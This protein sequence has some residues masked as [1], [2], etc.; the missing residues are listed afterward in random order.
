MAL[1]IIGGVLLSYLL[2]SIPT[3]FWYGKIF[4][5]IDIRKHGSGN[6][7]ATNSLR[8]MGREAGIIVI[9]IDMLKGVVAV[10]IAR[11]LVNYNIIQPSREISYELIF[12]IIAV[13]GHIFPVYAKFKGGKGI[14]T[15]FGMILAIDILTAG[16]CTCVFLLVLL[17]T[18]YVSLGSIMATISFPVM[19]LIFTKFREGG[20]SIMPLGIII[21]FIVL[22]THRKN[23]KRIFKGEERKFNL[24][25]E[26]NNKG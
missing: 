22:L 1:Y 18:R 9:L 11:L 13:I 3:A 7:G 25:K 14:A 5:D 16:I 12:A 20:P 6:S 19:V 17:L 15:L 8:V 24:G 21:S 26:D 4:H 10:E 23:I 2:G